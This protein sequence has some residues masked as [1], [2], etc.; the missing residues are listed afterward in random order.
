M[1]DKIVGLLAEIDP[2]IVAYTGHSM[3]RDGIIDSFG[4]IN[5][6]TGLE[7][8]FNIDIAPEYVIEANFENKDTIIKMVKYIISNKS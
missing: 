6:L 5:I 8:M 3:V 7:E 2:E 1:E 4:V